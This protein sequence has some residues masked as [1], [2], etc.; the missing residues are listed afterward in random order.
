MRRTLT[1]YARTRRLIEAAV[2]RPLDGR[3]RRVLADWAALQAA[4]TRATYR[5]LR[6]PRRRPRPRPDPDPE[7][8]VTWSPDLIS[9]MKLAL[10][11]RRRV[12]RSARIEGDE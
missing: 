11:P 7:P 4:P 3:E 10:F 8:R 9:D 2:G 6:S 1:L 12:P 5:R